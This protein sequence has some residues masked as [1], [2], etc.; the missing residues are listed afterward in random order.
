MEPEPSRLQKRRVLVVD[1]D[2][3]L[4]QIFQHLLEAYQYEV[5]TAANGALALKQIV[6]QDVDAIL[7]D[8]KM[9]EL[10]G[11][12]FYGAV[13]RIKPHLCSR[14]IF[15]TGAADDPKYRKFLSEVKSPVLRKPVESANLLETLRR[16]LEPQP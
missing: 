10:E 14:F 16:L 4:S 12:L 2:A 15:I 13:E 11:D 7:C 5:I 3:E 8:L 1:D 9:P 6:A